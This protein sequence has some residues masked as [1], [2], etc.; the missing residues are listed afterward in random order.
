M[1][2]RVLL[3]GLDGATFSILDPLIEEGV[4]PCLE[5]LIASGFRSQLTSVVPALTPPAWTSLM[6]GR[7][8]GNHGIFDF[9]RFDLRSGRPQ[10][11][12]MD[13]SDV[14]CEAIWPMV[15]RQGRE[16]TV[17][18]FPMTFPSQG[19]SGNVVPGWVPWRHLRLACRPKTLYDRLASAVPGFNPRELAMDMAL[20]ERVLEGCHGEE[21]YENLI[22][23]HIR[24]ERQW[25]EVA[26]YLMGEEPAAL[27]AVLFDGVD[28]LQHFCW[29]FLDRDIF[30]RSPSELDRRI[31]GWCLDYFREIDSFIG[32]LSASYGEDDAVFLAS[33]HGFGPTVE[34]FHVNAWL[35]REGHLAWA[36]ASN[37]EQK[38]A[39]TLGMG[40]MA[41]RFYE[42]DWQKSTAYCP[43]PSSNGIY[44]LPPGPDGSG[45]PREKYEHFR[46]TLM[47]GLLSFTD[48]V[49]GVRPVV[50]IY[51]R[52]E[53]FSGSA[54]EHAP[55]LTLIMRDGGLVSI[56]PSE[57]LLKHRVETTGAHRP[58]GVFIAAGRGIRRGVSGA[59]LS[60]L[61]VAP[62]LL[63]ALGLPLSADFEGRV[64]EALIEPAHLRANPVEF[65]AA[66]EKAMAVAA[67]G[68]LDPRMEA[69][70]MGQ[71]RALG[72][73]E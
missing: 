48:P 64:P 55:D 27:T 25:F 5:K 71:L 3:I 14:A 59:A 4:M 44:I 68:E 57:V 67:A 16:A 63:Y 69:E 28:K 54:M 73:M 70:V 62:T 13:S 23:L 52:E 72:Y 22:R 17:L 12:V 24:R 38:H 56:L 19:T 15:S 33:D 47:E 6:T 40:T 30:S 50:R 8:P 36:N 32:E 45:V 31:R 7:S 2:G 61:D 39:E 35:A 60:I 37:V 9:L 58:E 34:V 20:E 53:A 51:T 41:R 1:S 29:R 26:R 49:T 43:T 21:D 10:L 66:Q 65:A 11:R 18:N 46:R 42:I